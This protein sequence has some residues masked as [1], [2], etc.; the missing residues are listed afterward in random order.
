[1]ARLNRD[2]AGDIESANL[3]YA[4]VDDLDEMRDRSLRWAEGERTN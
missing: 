4:F 1:M 3:Y 2:L